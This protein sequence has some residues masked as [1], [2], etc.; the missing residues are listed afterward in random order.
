MTGRTVEEAI[1]AALEQ[2]GV[3]ETDAEIVIVEEP[4]SGMFGLRRSGARIRARVRPIQPRAKRPSRR[5]RAAPVGGERG[6]RRQAV[7]P[8]GPARKSNEKTE[9]EEARGKAA[10]SSAPGTTRRQSRQDQ[11]PGQNG[12]RKAPS[13]AAHEAAEATDASA[14]VGGTPTAG[15]RQRSR[16]RG[17]G[18]VDEWRA[19]R[20][21]SPMNLRV[22]PV[23]ALDRLRRR[24]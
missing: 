2:L 5:P 23:V 12:S 1:E 13:R 8:E 16:S 15:G 22:E 24:K 10:M 19:A 17:A 9:G 7:H 11:G 4:R 20:M 18:V 6:H 3:A 14:D 21:E